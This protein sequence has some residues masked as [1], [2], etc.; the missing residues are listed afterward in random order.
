[1]QHSEFSYHFSARLQPWV[2]YVPLTYSAADLT[3]KIEWLIAHDEA[4]QRI[5]R[6]ARAFGDS[7]LRLEDTLCYVAS[8][9]EAVGEVTGKRD[10][11]VPFNATLL[12]L[13]GYF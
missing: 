7:Y 11:N 2:H 9:L 10:A 1:M 8:A 6:N 13:T 3:E 4:A 5:A 12:P